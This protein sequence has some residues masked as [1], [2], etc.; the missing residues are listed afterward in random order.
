[1]HINLNC[2]FELTS[3][4]ISL[5]ERHP[6]MTLW[7]LAKVTWSSLLLP[8]I[9]MATDS[10]IAPTLAVRIG[11]CLALISGG[12]CSINLLMITEYNSSI[13]IIII[14]LLLLL[15][16]IIRGHPKMSPVSWV[17]KQYTFSDPLPSKCTDQHFGV[18]KYGFHAV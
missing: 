14:I 17:Y 6:K 9:W 1:M 12:M 15:I 3:L 13:T 18:P 4:T 5:Y 7:N 2:S 10:Y 11:I 16:I 8:V